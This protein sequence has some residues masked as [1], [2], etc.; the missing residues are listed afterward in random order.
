MILSVFSP[1]FNAFCVA[2]CFQ[3]QTGSLSSRACRQGRLEQYALRKSVN[4]L[5][6]F[7]DR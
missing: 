4:F 7:S 6:C 5:I 3:R 1:I 2:R